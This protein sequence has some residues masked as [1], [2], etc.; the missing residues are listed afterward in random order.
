MKSLSLSSASF[1]YEESGHHQDGSG[2]VGLHQVAEYEVAR[3][4]SEP[5]SHQGDSHGRGAEGGGEQFYSQA[6]QAVE[7]HRGDGAEDAGENEVHGGAVDQVDEEGRG[8]T[9]Q[10]RETKK[11]LPSQCV[12][13]N[14]RPEVGRGR[15]EGDDEAVDEDLIVRDGGGAV[16][17]GLVLSCV[18]LHFQTDNLREPNNK[19]SVVS[20]VGLTSHT[21][22]VLLGSMA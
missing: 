13:V 9:E 15:G 6:V 1:T 7:T 14:N 11:E 17:R 4:G 3:D 16:R 12:H 5:G 2:T 10:H 22:N 8:S 18:Q 19:R 20:E 21:L